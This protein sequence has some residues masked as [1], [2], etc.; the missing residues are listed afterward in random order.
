MIATSFKL[1]T[2][3]LLLAYF[4]GIST[5]SAKDPPEKI[6]KDIPYYTPSERDALATGD[7]DYRAERCKLDVY[8]P[9]HAQ[10]KKLPVV[11]WFH[12][13]GL[14][15]GNKARPRGFENQPIIVVAANYRFLTKAAPREVIEDAAAAVNWTIGNIEQH[16][17]DRG[18][19]SVAG[20]S[21]GGYL[22]MMIGMNSTYLAAHDRKNTDLAG[23]YSVS[24]QCTTHYEIAELPLKAEGKKRPENFKRDNPIQLNE[25]APLSY[26]DRKL[27]PLYLLCGDPAVEWPARVEENQLLAAMLK[28]VKDH[29][30]VEFR[31]Y[32]GKDHDSCVEPAVEDIRKWVLGDSA[33]RASSP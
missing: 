6:L 5:I 9:A 26:T 21:A 4:I 16:D 10:G 7:L 27:P 12:G 22:S 15:K 24:G 19:V 3:L 23:V 18:R 17:G 14:V 13:G 1:R 8:I 2:F 32:A 31:S 25:F 33:T 30:T 20:H 11:V 28:T 29:N